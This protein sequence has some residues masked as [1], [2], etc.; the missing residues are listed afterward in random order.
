MTLYA[1]SDNRIGFGIPKN[2]PSTKI[3]SFLIYFRRKNK[4]VDT[5]TK[6]KKYNKCIMLCRNGG[7]CIKKEKQAKYERNQI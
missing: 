1:K 4:G 3:R 2:P 6:E 7:Q 5:V